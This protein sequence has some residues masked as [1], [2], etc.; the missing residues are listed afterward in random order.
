MDISI[1]ESNN[2]INTKGNVEFIIEDGGCVV[3]VKRSC[4]VLTQY[5]DDYMRLILYFMLVGVQ[6]KIKLKS[7]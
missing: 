4:T 2:K 5:R 3:F 1:A 7:I 6:K